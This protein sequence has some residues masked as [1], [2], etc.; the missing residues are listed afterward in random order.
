MFGKQ[1]SSKEGFEGIGNVTLEFLAVHHGVE[2]SVLQQKLGALETLRQFLADRLLDYPRPSEANQGA[3]LGDIEIAKHGVAGR[4]APRRRIGK[5]RNKWDTD[6][7]E[8]RQRR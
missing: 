8:L 5:H 6:L 4:N 3:R 1:A 2:E 7:I